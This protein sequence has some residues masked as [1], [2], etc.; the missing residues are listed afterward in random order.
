MIVRDLLILL[1][2]T[3]HIKFQNE[4]YET[5]C[6]CSSR[7]EGVIPYLERTIVY[8]CPTSESGVSITLKNQ[9]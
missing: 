9:I 3:A 1:K 7:S 2:H 5:I 8:W 6:E 4:A